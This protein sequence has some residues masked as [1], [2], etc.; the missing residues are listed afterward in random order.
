[1][2][3]HWASIGVGRLFFGSAVDRLGID[4]FL[5]LSTLTSVLGTGLFALTL[6]SPMS[7]IALV[8]AGLGLAAIYPCMMTRTPQR[9]GAVTPRGGRDHPAHRRPG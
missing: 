7:A 8:L 3:L 5:R 9:P 2:T 4:S 1:V 6:S